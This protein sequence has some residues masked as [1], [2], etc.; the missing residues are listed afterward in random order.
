MIDVGRRTGIRGQDRWVV[1]APA[2]AARLVRGASPYSAPLPAEP[3][4][5]QAWATS[6]RLEPPAVLAPDRPGVPPGGA[7]LAAASR[8][9]GRPD[10]RW[11][12]L[13][14]IA[15]LIGLGL[16]YSSMA[17]APTAVLVAV[18]PPLALGAV[19]GSAHA[20]AALLAAS[21]FLALR[22]PALAVGLLAGA[23]AAVDPLVI[24]TLPF[25]ALALRDPLRRRKGLWG[26]AIGGAVLVV[27]VAI[28]DLA[29]FAEALVRAPGTGPGLG[30][31]A[32][33]LYVGLAG[34]GFGRVAQ[35]VLVTL[36]GA[37]LAAVLR[38]RDRV[39]VRLAGALV[40]LVGVF[41]APG[42][43]PEAVALPIALG[44]LAVVSREDPRLEG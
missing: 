23:A 4:G 35:V 2:D 34:P 44:L 14:A 40:A 32:L 28:L 27:P 38:R 43:S 10:P 8:L 33:G 41:A 13:A 36:L 3:E 9:L 12:T 30:L 7:A 37:C 16:R 29:G 6:F 18:L 17:G 25:L 22:G 31:D 26:A 11:L 1:Q 24:P 19:F 21:A 20:L 42:L 39:D 5:R 15:V